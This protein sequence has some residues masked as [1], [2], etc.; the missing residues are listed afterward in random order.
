MSPGSGLATYAGEVIDLG[1][2][3]AVTVVVERAD[4]ISQIDQ[5]DAANG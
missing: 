3:T 1:G 2:I 4:F 5:W